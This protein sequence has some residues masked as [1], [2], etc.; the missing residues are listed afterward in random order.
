MSKVEFS[1]DPGQTG[2]VNG[3]ISGIATSVST[4][5]YAD[6]AVQ[7][8]ADTL[9]F[10]FEQDMDNAAQAAPNLFYHVYNWG[11]SYNDRSKVGLPAFRLWKLI[12]T[13]SGRNRQVG[14]TFLPETVPSPIEPELIEVGVKEDIHIFT[15]KAPVMEYGLPVTIAPKLS[16]ILVFFQDGD[17]RVSKKPITTVPGYRTTTHMFT[18]FFLSWWQSVAPSTFDNLVRPE[19]ERDVITN[20]DLKKIAQKATR[21]RRKDIGIDVIDFRTGEALAKRHM[22][23]NRIDYLRR[24]RRR[25]AER[26]D[27]DD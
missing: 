21:R 1:M 5:Q 11:D 23:K 4:R 20:K 10:L 19:L 15:W 18:G 13:G 2:I 25:K 14:F 8:A 16:K 3:Y 6:S 17:I 12:T 22:E 9:S 7:Y 26:Y 27:Y 24:A